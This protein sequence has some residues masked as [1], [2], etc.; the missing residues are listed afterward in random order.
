MIQ[1]YQ[2]SYI[3]VKIIGLGCLMPLSTIFLLYHAYGSQFYWWRK[4]EYPD[5][6][7]DLPQVT[8]E[9]YHIMLNTLSR[10][11]FELT[12]IVAISTDCTDSCKS[13]Y[14]TI[15]TMTAP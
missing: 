4:S 12:T 10:A 11:G 6:S 14:H 8:D 9:F 2:K 13:N 5:K 3:F 1:P 7:T 15:M